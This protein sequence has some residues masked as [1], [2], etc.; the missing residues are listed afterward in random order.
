L[1][2]KNID[3]GMGLE[4]LAS[5]M[6]KVNTNF[7][8][9]IFK[10]IVSQIKL[11]SKIKDSKFLPQINAIADH[12]RAVSF[13][14]SDG[15]FPSN[16]ERGYVIRKLIRKAF[17][18]GY[19]LGIEK[20]FLYKLVPIVS[21]VM[22]KPYPE[23]NERRE[24]ISQVVKAEEERFNEVLDSGIERLKLMIEELKKRGK[25]VL[26]GEE[27]FKLYDTYGFPFELTKEIASI[28]GIRLDEKGYMEAFE[29]QRK[30]SKEKSKI[31]QEIF[32][33]KSSFF[34]N[35]PE[36]KF[37]G[38]DRLNNNSKILAIFDIELKNRLDK[39]KEKE[40]GFIVV[41]ETPF[42]AESGG[43]VGDRGEIL[44]SNLKADVLDTK[45]KEGI[46]FHKIKV[47]KGEIN[48]NQDIE[49]KVNREVRLSTARNHTATHLLQ[50]ALRTILG[51]HV[52]QSGSYVSN[53]KLRFDFTHF[54]TL[55][56]NELIKVEKLVNEFIIRNDEL[57]IS[58]M[59]LK[60]AKEIGA[61][62]FFGEKYKEPVRVIE[63]GDYSKELCGGTHVRRTG[64][65]G[66]FKI[67]S[68]ISI[69]SGIRRIEAITGTSAYEKMKRGEQIINE[70]KEILKTDE[71]SIIKALKSLNDE[72]KN[73]EILI[74][75]AKI[76]E[77]KEL[78]Q[79]LLSNVYDL[80]GVKFIKTV[81]KEAPDYIRKL[82]DSIKKNAVSP[83]FIVI[84]SK[85]ED[86]INIFIGLTNSLVDKGFDAREF[87]N[88]ISPIIV[89]G[90]GGRKDFVQVGGKA[91]DNLEKALDKIE[92]I[93]KEKVKI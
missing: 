55:T 70:I 27:A 34:N 48:I 32:D 64:D 68:S 39:L 62:A 17:W 50:S 7:E 13:A 84:G 78:A 91:I 42:Y 44:F 93:L 41:K 54:K 92:E 61:L 53:E 57:K 86:K 9:D 47:K 85:E 11:I 5:V 26:E 28:S 46:Y 56:D 76:K 33:I 89:G 23:L 30:K 74:K 51:K 65:I 36:T 16:E 4:R 40:I 69:A 75:K 45:E 72:L 43:Q 24:N 88:K 37:I 49:L 60:E 8:I 20:P 77:L 73:K 18:H 87:S 83:T 71:D 63:I 35:I 3:T 67:I 14:I 25:N 82:I 31:S 59:S 38:Y 6:Q 12:I 66:I 58:N 1:P 2:A 22:I 79:D 81:I 52:E 80:N 21:K 19:N 29:K 90:G 10:P 15:V